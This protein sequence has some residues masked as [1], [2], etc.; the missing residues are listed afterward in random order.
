MGDDPKVIYAHYKQH[1]PALKRAL[2]QAVFLRYKKNE[3]MFERWSTTEALEFAAL[4]AD[5]LPVDFDLQQAAQNPIKDYSW[6]GNLPLEKVLQD[7]TPSFAR[8]PHGGQQES[9]ALSWTEDDHG[10]ISHSASDLAA[11]TEKF[12][13]FIQA[14]RPIQPVPNLPLMLLVVDPVDQR[15]GGIFKAPG[16]TT[17]ALLMQEVG[18]GQQFMLVTQKALSEWLLEAQST[19]KSGKII[20]VGF[21]PEKMIFSFNKKSK[22]FI[23]DG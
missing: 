10:C 14:V 22:T 13:E 8:L 17:Y 2:D 18:N 12:V 7:N 21:S 1:Q 19:L 11:G 20:R 15:V 3:A 16:G 5:F 9:L 23:L 6:I 4:Q